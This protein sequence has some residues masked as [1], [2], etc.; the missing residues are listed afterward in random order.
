VRAWPQP[1]RTRMPTT[2]NAMPARPRR[3]LILTML[4]DQSTFAEQFWF[5]K[6]RSHLPT[7]RGKRSIGI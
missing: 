6:T 1:V 7:V 5:T 4:T 3:H 2:V